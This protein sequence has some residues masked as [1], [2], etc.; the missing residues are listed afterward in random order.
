MKVLWWSNHPTSPTGYGTQTALWTRRLRDAGHT[1]VISSNWGG[2]QRAHEWEGIPVLPPGEHRFAQD[3]LAR[4]IDAVDPD[5]VWCLYDAWPIKPGPLRDRNVALWTPVDHNPLPP[6]VKNALVESRCTPVAYSQFGVEAMRINGLD[7]LYVP[8]GIDT[9]IFQ[10]RPRNEARAR[11]GFDQ[12]QFLIGMVAANK[13]GGYLR[14]GWDVAFESVAWLARQHDDVH[15]YVHSK[16]SSQMGIDLQVCARNYDLPKD[17]L[18]FLP[19]A[20]HEYGIS[21]EK[22]SWI[23]SAF[24]VLLSPSLGEGFG[25]PVL[26]A[27]ACGV[28]VIV[29]DFSA[30]TELC[31]AGWRARAHN[32]YDAEQAAD[33]GRPYDFEVRRCLDEAYQARDEQSLAVA[34]RQFGVMYD[35][36]RVWDEFW[37]PA[38]EILAADVPSTEPICV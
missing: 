11:L 10:P 33:W 14:K 7:P 25:L 13:S 30:Q 20:V 26:E 6:L 22:M 24:D 3:S 15:L 19:A 9:N 32:L 21:D 18:T 37:T 2:D 34:A 23:Y 28:P 1:V 29:T 36:D 8:H 17:G 16:P 27:Q 38:L 35:A 31:G 12:D 5:L 4:D